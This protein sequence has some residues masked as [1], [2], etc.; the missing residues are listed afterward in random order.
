MGW[1]AR[2][3]PRAGVMWRSWTD[4]PAG[5][6]A[7]PSR[8]DG[9]A[10]SKCQTQRRCKGQSST[11]S[12]EETKRGMRRRG[13]PDGLAQGF[14]GGLSVGW[15]IVRFWQGRAKKGLDAPHGSLLPTHDVGREPPRVCRRAAA[16]REAASHGPLRK[17][18]HQ[19]QQPPPALPPKGG[20][21]PQKPDQATAAAAPRRRRLFPALQR[22]GPHGGAARRPRRDAAAPRNT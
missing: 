10:A 20:P 8:G 11:P 16:A 6:D 22:A 12:Y 7:L 3:R 5:C 19:G 13:V 1:R 14:S 21:G 15:K 18:A 2:R 9:G 17:N 4:F